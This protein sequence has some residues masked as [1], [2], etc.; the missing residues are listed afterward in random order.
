VIMACS[1]FMERWIFAD[2]LPFK[3][4]L[5]FFFLL[6]VSFFGEGL[7][8]HHKSDLRFTWCTSRLVDHPMN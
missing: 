2:T 8:T 4:F 7:L 1:Q 5:S 3:L 6:F